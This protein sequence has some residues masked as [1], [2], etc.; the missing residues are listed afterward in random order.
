MATGLGSL[1]PYVAAAAP[2]I[3]WVVAGLAAFAV[4]YKFSDW[5]FNEVE[6]QEKIANGMDKGLDW[7][8]EGLG[9]SFDAM[10]VDDGLAWCIVNARKAG[11]FAKD[12]WDA[13][14]EGWNMLFNEAKK[15]IARETNRLKKAN[16]CIKALKK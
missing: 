14:M 7:V 15:V 9:M 10:R 5:L 16:N 2:Y 1:V 6:I 12:S 4:S 3:P 8:I 13:S 11:A